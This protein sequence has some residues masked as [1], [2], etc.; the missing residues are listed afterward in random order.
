M[1]KVVACIIA[2]TVSQRL[3]L[4]VLRDIS[5]GV[6]MIEFLIDRV[7]T[8]AAVDEIYLCTSTEPVDD[9]F[10]DV[11]CRKNIKIF[12]GSTDAVIE[13]MIKVGEIENADIVL[14]ITGDNPFS[15]VE[16]VDRQID[17]LL[18]EN[19]DYI[20]LVDVPIGAAIEVIKFEALRDCYSKMD[21]SISEYLML[22]IF[23][24]NNYKCGIIKPFV[25]D[26][27]KFSI[28]VD[29]LVDLVR[30]KN[31]V[32]LSKENF[33]LENIAKFL[34]DDKLDN[35]LPKKEIALGGK[36]KYP[37][38]KEITFEEFS[39][40]MKRRKEASLLIKLYE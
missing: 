1:A 6:S 17:F 40:D 26:F 37:Y 8:I 3:P 4:K 28:T 36:I 7:K 25:E 16:Y 31:I 19:L 24:P 32:T 27:S 34:N 20:R 15:S 22:F 14:R 23:E 35:L 21:P 9:I 12:R 18:N 13:R 2:R 33:K 30:A 29:T 39:S 10:E 38:D 5:F 11:V